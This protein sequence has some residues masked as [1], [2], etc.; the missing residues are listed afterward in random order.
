[1]VSRTILDLVRS[2]SV[3]QVH[4]SSGLLYIQ[5]VFDV[6]ARIVSK[7]CNMITTKPK[8]TN[9][10]SLSTAIK[11]ARCWLSP[12]PLLSN[13]LQKV[14]WLLFLRNTPCLLHARIRS[15]Q[16]QW[17]AVTAGAAWNIG[18]W[19][20]RFSSTFMI[21]ATLPHLRP[22]NQR[23]PLAEVKLGGQQF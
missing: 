17:N 7:T 10:S 14:V 15:P 3:R 12:A 16:P 23:E 13:L 18:N 11:L 22:S 8:F 5:S 1:M 21:A 19:K 2:T 9:L 20:S 4:N 6:Q